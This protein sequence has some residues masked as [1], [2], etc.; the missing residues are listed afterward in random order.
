M[1]DIDS[2]SSITIYSL[3]T[4]ATT[5]QLSINGVGIIKQSANI[6]GFSSTVTAWSRS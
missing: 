4:V 2:E 1:I 6:N 3:N 5:N